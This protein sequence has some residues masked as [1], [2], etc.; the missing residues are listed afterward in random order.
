LSLLFSFVGVVLVAFFLSLYIRRRPTERNEIQL[1]YDSAT[2]NKSEERMGRTRRYSMCC[3]RGRKRMKM[4][5]KKGKR[6]S[7]A[8][9]RLRR[10]DYAIT[11]SRKAKKRRN[12]N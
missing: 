11:A 1:V 9:Q 8:V 12:N 2:K 4:E 3:K 7:E 10:Y 6:R 5:R